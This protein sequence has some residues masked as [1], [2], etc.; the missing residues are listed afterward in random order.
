DLDNDGYADEVPIGIDGAND[1]PRLDMPHTNFNYTK[2]RPYGLYGRTKLSVTDELD[3][4]LGS[5]VT[6]YDA[7][8]KNANTFFNNFGSPST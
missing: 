1:L 7:D 4:I 8:A 5:R 2:S 6:W 3:V